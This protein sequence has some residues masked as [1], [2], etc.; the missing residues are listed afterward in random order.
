MSVSSVVAVL[1][2]PVGRLGI[3]DSRLAMVMSM[4]PPGAVR[5]ADPA[6]M[7]CHSERVSRRAARAFKLYDGHSV[8][9][10]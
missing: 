7:T 9:G 2:V 8:A 5:S 6:T 10:C 1:S 4:A 3:G